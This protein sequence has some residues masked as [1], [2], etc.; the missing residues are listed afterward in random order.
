[1]NT[2]LERV[3]Q[4]DLKT[5]TVEQ[6]L[7]HCFSS[8]ADFNN[9]IYSLKLVVVSH[10]LAVFSSNFQSTC[11][12]IKIIYKKSKLRFTYFVWFMISFIFAMYLQQVLH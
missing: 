2:V 9:Y 11:K 8:S 3:S 6:C 10:N 1:M 5:S 12:K 7:C 4:P